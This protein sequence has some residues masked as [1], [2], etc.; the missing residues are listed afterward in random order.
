VFAERIHF[1]KRAAGHAGAAM[2]EFF[3]F[4]YVARFARLFGPLGQAVVMIGGGL[5]VSRI[6]RAVGETAFSFLSWLFSEVP[7]R[8]QAVELVPELPQP[9]LLE[10]ILNQPA[11]VPCEASHD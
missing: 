10:R 1:G 6:G 3:F 2:A 7:D 9:S 5:L 11:I 8:P 4:K